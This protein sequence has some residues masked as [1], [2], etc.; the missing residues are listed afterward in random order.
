MRQR[1]PLSV[2]ACALVAGVFLNPL[3]AAAQA[4]APAAT[5]PATSAKRPA[6]AAPA[7][8]SLSFPSASPEASVS[9]EGPRAHHRDA[10][11]LHR[12]QARGRRGDG[13]PARRQGRLRPPSAAPTSRRPCRCGPT[14][15]SASPRSRRRSPRP[16]LDPPRRRQAAAERSGQQ[17]HPAFRNTT[18][19]VAPAA[20]AA[21]GSPVSTVAAKR[22]ITVRDLMTQSSGSAT[23]ATRR[24]ARSTRPRVRR[25]VFRQQDRA[26]R[27]VDREAGDAAVR[28]P[29][30]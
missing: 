11:G 17:V 16:R 15:S 18:V 14:R 20:N 23:A 25:V 21:P 4:A 7:G 13:D 3:G 30:G 9:P 5:A 12:S 28:R 26:D 29:A 22:Q 24:R 6:A 2:V 1:G 27:R 8:A 10:A 19:M